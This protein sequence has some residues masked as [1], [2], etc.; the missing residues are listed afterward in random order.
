MFNTLLTNCCTCDCRYCPLRRNA[1]AKHCTLTVPN[2]RRGS[3]IPRLLLK[4]GGRSQNRTGD[5]RIFSPLLYQLS[6]PATKPPNGEPSKIA[7]FQAKTSPCNSIFDNIFRRC[8]GSWL[9]HK[10]RL[11]YNGITRDTGHR[12]SDCTN[13]IMQK[14]RR[15]QSSL[16]CGAPAPLSLP[17][18]CHCLL[19]YSSRLKR[20][21]RKIKLKD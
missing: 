13:G 15:H 12:W 3:K 11:W 19:D 8:G 17:A 4:N 21:R 18:T 10:Q 6:Y 7:G 20:L 2:S 5:T 9:V 1:D 16:D 14:E